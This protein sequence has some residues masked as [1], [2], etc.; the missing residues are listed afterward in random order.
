MPPKGRG[1]KRSSASAE[2]LLEDIRQ[3]VDRSLAVES[4]LL[5]AFRLFT[6]TPL[7]LDAIIR[8]P[9]K[10]VFAHLTAIYG[11]HLVSFV[12][13]S[14]PALAVLP[15]SL[16]TETVS[17]LTGLPLDEVSLIPLIRLLIHAVYHKKS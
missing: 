2:S 5:D 15:V 11:Q 16:R 9:V 17:K 3:E 14:A 10:V 8:L 7:N 4:N 12:I 13:S 1:R 6:S